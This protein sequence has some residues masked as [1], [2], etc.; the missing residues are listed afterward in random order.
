[1]MRDKKPNEEMTSLGQDLLEAAKEMLAHSRGEI[2][3][4]TYRA[5]DVGKSDNAGD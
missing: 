3:L 2:V 1:M 4:P 5:K